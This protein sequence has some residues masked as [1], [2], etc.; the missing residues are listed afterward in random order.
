MASP[1]KVD[2]C[3]EIYIQK[4]VYNSRHHGGLSKEILYSENGYVTE[5][6]FESTAMAGK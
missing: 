6:E 3:K 5:F 4:N 1:I 2:G